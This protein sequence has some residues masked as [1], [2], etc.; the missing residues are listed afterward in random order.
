MAEAEDVIHTLGTDSTHFWHEAEFDFARKR[1]DC[2]LQSACSLSVGIY[3]DHPV[4][5]SSRP[6]H[7]LLVLSGFVTLRLRIFSMIQ[8]RR[9]GQAGHAQEIKNVKERLIERMMK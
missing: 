1:L 4:K 5:Q 3:S 6:L 8:L 7:V 9:D 2:G